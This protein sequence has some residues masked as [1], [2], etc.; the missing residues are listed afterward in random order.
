[1]RL[2]WVS[3]IAPCSCPTSWL[4]WPITVASVSWV[5]STSCSPA[6][7]AISVGREVPVIIGSWLIWSLLALRVAVV[8][9]KVTCSMGTT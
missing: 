8:P 4:S 3:S 5:A 7:P 2:A 6:A 1:M 9:L